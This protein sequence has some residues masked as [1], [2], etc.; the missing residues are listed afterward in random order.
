MD[1]TTVGIVSE[2]R[3]RNRYR[4]SNQMKESQDEFTVRNYRASPVEKNYPQGP[5]HNCRHRLV[6]D[7]S[8]SFRN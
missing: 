2:V 8:H 6:D 5:C 4:K 7:L 3:R 1:G